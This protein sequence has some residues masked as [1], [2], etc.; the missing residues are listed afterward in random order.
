MTKKRTYRPAPG[1]ALNGLS[2][3]TLTLNQDGDVEVEF[4]LPCEQTTS[5]Y[6]RQLKGT[7]TL[8]AY[9]DDELQEACMQLFRIVRD[10]VQKPDEEREAVH[11]DECSSS[12]CCRKYN[13]LVTEEDIERLAKHLQLSPRQ[14]ASEYTTDPVDWCGDFIAQLACEDDEEDDEERCVF[15]KRTDAGQLR[16]SVYEHRPQI[17]RDFDMK[18]CDDFVAIE[19]VAVR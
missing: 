3:S 19:D 17:C 12:A 4:D 7:R 13:V 1:F 9:D 14:F 16:C 5:Q 11:C 18:T 10:R 15:L 2:I 8:D 6:Q